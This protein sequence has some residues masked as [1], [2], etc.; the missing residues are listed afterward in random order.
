MKKNK[1]ILLIVIF[2]LFL[3]NGF[4]KNNIYKN[5]SPKYKKWLD[6]V[7]YHITDTERKVFLQL[8]SDKE[9]DS[10]IEIFW[11]QRDPTPGTPRNEFKEKL[12][13]RFKYV[14]KY[15]KSSRP[16]WMTDRGRIYMILGKPSSVE[17]VDELGLYPMQIWNY[18]GMEKY[19]LTSHFRIVFYRR[20][21][22][23]EFKLYDPASDGPMALVVRNYEALNKIK[24]EFDNFKV[25][26]YIKEIAP[27]IAEAAITLIPNEIPFNYSPD[28]RSSILLSKIS[29]VPY[30]EVDLSY[31]TSFLNLK[32]IVKVDYSMNYIASYNSISVYK[33]P[34]TNINYL[35]FSISP[36][37]VS[38][39]F[40]EETGKYFC[41]FKLSVVIRKGGKQI[42]SYNKTYP[43]YFTKEEV[44][45]RVK[46]GIAIK[47]F[48][49]IIKGRYDVTILIQNAVNKEFSYFE[50]LIDIESAGKKYIWGPLVSYKIKK[51]SGLYLFPY[52]VNNYFVDIDPKNIFSVNDRIFVSFCIEKPEFKDYHVSLV[53]KNKLGYSEYF[54]EYKD[55]LLKNN[56]NCFIKEVENPGPGSYFVKVS[57]LKGKIPMSVSEKDFIVS[58]MGS[59]VHPMSAY[60]LLSQK[61]SFIQFFTLGSQYQKT[62]NYEKAKL[63]YEKALSLNQKY[64]PIIKSLSR[65]YLQLKNYEKALE[66]SELLKD[67]KKYEFDYFALKGEIFY[68]KGN[69]D[70]ALKYLIKANKIYNSDFRVI[71]LI[72]LSFL[73][74]GNCKEALKSFR[75][76]LAL[77]KNQPMV[78]DLL[79]RCNKILKRKKE[80]N[81]N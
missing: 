27:S 49:P 43:L 79:N 74:E 9:R 8:K 73:K 69:I 63:M 2:L 40:N 71:N 41:V 36:K 47:D 37:R 5:L 61:N 23:G 46:R 30:K 1:P 39:D 72:G 60:K 10:F 59:V 12:E 31:A 13:K 80:K 50:K 44:K 7:H 32:G 55:F 33:D 35:Y 76:S 16:G 64:I 19:G 22:I 81:T 45:S 26:K 25:Y 52:K 21:G 58:P 15:F 42:F 6:L 62:G 3:S 24:D 70:E 18:Y 17:H 38:L 20:K 14:N 68:Y 28:L 57:V 51:S 66:I 75:A 34:I 11:K 54:K 78:R 56:G 4:S 53:L 29:E 67:K 65:V 48:I 77:N